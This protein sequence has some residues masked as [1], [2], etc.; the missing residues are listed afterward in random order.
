MP[1]AIY[2]TEEIKGSF[3]SQTEIFY[4][5]YDFVILNLSKSLSPPIAVVGKEED[6]SRT[7]VDTSSA[8]FAETRDIEK[9][10]D[11]H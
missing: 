7:A 4:Q 5:I 3:I 2:K 9:P 1:L 11:N 6:S 8:L 10:T